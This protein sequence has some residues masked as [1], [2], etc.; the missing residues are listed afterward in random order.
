MFMVIVLLWKLC[1]CV[2]LVCLVRHA[3]SGEDVERRHSPRPAQNTQA[4]E[5]DPHT[6]GGYIQVVFYMLFQLYF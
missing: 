3:K 5:E 4:V 1:N 2:L 6:G